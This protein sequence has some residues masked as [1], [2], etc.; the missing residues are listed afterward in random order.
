M[1][2]DLIVE[3]AV[4]PHERQ[5]ARSGLL[6]Q[7]A[8]VIGAIITVLIVLMAFVGP[9]LTPHAPN[10]TIGAPFSPPSGAAPLGT[11]FIGRDV[12]S[13][14]LAGGRTVLLLAFV[15][16]AL[17]YLLGGLVGI[18][19]ALK[20]GWLDAAL[21]RGV[22]VLLAFPPLIFLLVVA[23]GAG[24]SLPALVIAMAIINAPGLARILRSAVLE[25]STHGYVEAAIARGERTGSLIR[26]EIIPNILGVIAADMGLRLSFAILLLAS[27]SFLGLGVQP[28]NAD[29]ARMVSENLSGISEQPWAVLAPALLLAVLI[30]SI[31][32]FADALARITGVS[33]EV[34]EGEA[35]SR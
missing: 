31:N 28:P 25:V 19:A 34:L 2:V 3:D 20:G 9:Y 33:A 27:V 22:D 32:L 14:M 13:R 6:S 18:I 15:A 12:L 7:P 23:T 10:L 8:G 4:E 17:T 1:S 24:Q 30:I 16:T 21:M 26:R 35:M 11:D 29:W 5:R